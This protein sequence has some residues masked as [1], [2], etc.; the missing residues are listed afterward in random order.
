VTEILLSDASPDDAAE[1][2]RVMIRTK[3]ES[4]AQP[5]DPHDCDFDFC[6]DRW[7]RYLQQGSGAQQSLGDGFVI[8]AKRG[9]QL[10]GFAAYHHTRRLE[11]DAELQA[12]YVLSGHQ[13][14]GT[15]T[16]LLSEILRRLAADGSRSLCV[17]YAPG[18]PYKRFY[19]KHGAV[20]INPHWAVWRTLPAPPEPAVSR[21]EA[22][23]DL[24]IAGDES[25]L[26][27]LLRQDP[28]LIRTRSSRK[29][30]ATLLHYV[31]ANGVED[32]RQKTPPNAVAIARILL[33]A[34]AEVDATANAYGK[35][36]TLSLAA[37]SVHPLRAGVQNAL[38]ELLLQRGAAID[39]APGGSNPLLA[40]LRNGRKQAAEFLAACGARLDMEGA[41]GVGRLDLVKSLHSSASTKEVDL[42][43]L[44][45]C[46]YGRNSVVD[47]LLRQGVDPLAQADTGLNGLHWAVVGGQ[48]E[49]IRLLLERGT[50]LDARNLYGGT[51]LGTAAWAALHGDPAV[52]YVPIIEALIEAGAKVEEA[53]YPT[54]N[55]R[56]DEVL[57]KYGAR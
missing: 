42:G 21:F 1:I 37:S 9:G 13:A 18:N 57:R 23:V 6:F 36:T 12:I 39:G 16:K 19:A 3:Q 8:L 52:D 56:V 55:E 51:A 17:G 31:A 46:E 11:C 45:A 27:A 30:R 38:L 54:G 49:T 22:A 48:L 29:H 40:A 43:F 50:A 34:G 4:F 2:A 44:W 10:I 15:G 47:F 28:E 33:D 20:E 25:A 41:A 35:D 26:E 5:L 24:V 32:F 7:Q 53:G 14:R